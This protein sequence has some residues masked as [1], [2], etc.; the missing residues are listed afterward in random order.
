MI[1]FL[2]RLLL[3]LMHLHAL[4]VDA[5]H[6]VFDHMIL[7]GG[8]HALKDQEQGVPILGVEPILQ[9][10]EPLEAPLPM[11]AER[12]FLVRE[13]ALEVGRVPLD[14]PSIVRAHAKSI[15]VHST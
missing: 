12:F 13:R 3:E 14:R 8:V 10:L 6:H 5:G 2:S 4:R 11:T 15:D 1:Q 9:F 7:S